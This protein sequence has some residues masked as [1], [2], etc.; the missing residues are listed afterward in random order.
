MFDEIDYLKMKK[1]CE[2]NKNKGKVKYNHIW[3]DAKDKMLVHPKSGVAVK[4]LENDVFYGFYKHSRIDDE[5]DLN[6]KEVE[7]PVSEDAEKE[8]SGLGITTN[9][10]TK[11]MLYFLEM[12]KHLNFKDFVIASY[13]DDFEC[14]AYTM[15]F[16]ILLKE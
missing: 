16:T 13:D 12:H 11:Y 6:M 15:H 9:I 1:I 4:L 10:N 5:T 8:F 7:R 14:Y 2:E 3:S